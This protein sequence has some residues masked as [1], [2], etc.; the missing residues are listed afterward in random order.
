MRLKDRPEFNQK[1]KPLTCRSDDTVFSAVLSMTDNNFGSIIIVDDNNHVL[2]MLTERDLFK[3]I[4]AKDLD[5]KLIKVK[6]VMTAPVKTAK[7]DD[8]LLDWLRMMSNERFRRLPIVDN[9]DRLI[10]VMTQGDFVSYTW[11]ELIGRMKEMSKATLN[12]AVN[13]I[14]IMVSLCLY[15]MISATVLIS[16]YLGTRG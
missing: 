14:T 5:A 2:G 7:A 3:K 11:P 10:A 4:I 8:D 15:I 6:E 9:D 12:K 1:Q 13:P 16:Y